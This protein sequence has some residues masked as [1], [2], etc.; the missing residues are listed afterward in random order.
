LKAVRVRVPASTAN[1][2][3]GFD[4]LGMA[5]NLYLELTMELCEEEPGFFARENL[6]AQGALAVFDT[7][8]FPR[9]GLRLQ[10][11]SQIPLAKGLGSSAA[12][13][14]AGIGAANRLLGD[15]LSA[16]EQLRLAVKLEGHPDNVLPAFVGGVTV[17]MTS[18]EQVYYQQIPGDEQLRLVVAVPTYRLATQEARA[19]LPEQVAWRDAVANLQRSSFLVA[20]LY[21]KDY[22]QL[23]LA[24]RDSLAEPWR[25]Q[26]IP[27]FSRIVAAAEDAGAWAAVIS[28]AGPSIAAWCRED[29]AEVVAR[30]MR[31]ALL[32]AQV[33]A[34]LLVLTADN[35]GMSF[36]AVN[37]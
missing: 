12:A 27:G 1:L 13:L 23:R 19:V 2:G 37:D 11:Q 15:P 7:A 25:K 17:A 21:R 31:E 36:S 22:A 8:G 14:V 20:A 30:A 16:E 29:N 5:L 4:T 35:A 33:D 18:G 26:L 3:A 34:D 32:T 10:T 28:G 9:R 6:I 24:L